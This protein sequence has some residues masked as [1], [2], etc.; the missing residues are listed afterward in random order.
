MRAIRPQT[1]SRL[2]RQHQSSSRSS[3]HQTHLQRCSIA[4]RRPQSRQTRQHSRSIRLTR[5]IPESLGGRKRAASELSDAAYDTPQDLM[6]LQTLMLVPSEA[7]DQLAQAHRE[8]PMVSEIA[9]HIQFPWCAGDEEAV[10][11]E[12]SGMQ[13][14][15]SLAAFIKQTKTQSVTTVSKQNSLIEAMSVDTAHTA[16]KD[17]Q[18]GRY[19]E[20]SNDVLIEV[21][22]KKSSRSRIPSCQVLRGSWPAPLRKDE[23]FDHGHDQQVAEL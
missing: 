6:Q 12:A 2:D 20:T 21:G 5:T 22:W 9:V 18:Q 7:R 1:T 8:E 14:R 19:D 13:S 17:E 3:L 11:G 15:Q 4:H 16:A 23:G 10:G